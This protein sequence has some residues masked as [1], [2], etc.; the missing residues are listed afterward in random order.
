MRQLMEQNNKKTDQELLNLIESIAFFY[1][2]AVSHN[3]LADILDIPVEKVKEL[4]N[5]LADEY[6][7]RGINFINRHNELQIVAV[8]KDDQIL[9]K[10]EQNSKNQV[11][12]PAT[13]ETLSICL[14]LQKANE[15]TIDSIRGVRSARTIK[16]LLRRGYLEKVD[17]DK[18]KLS[19]E[20][21]KQLGVVS[22]DDIPHASTIKLKLIALATNNE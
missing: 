10:L 5:K 4:A 6:S 7:D 19:T 20:A 15:A 3:D 14:Y 2:E 12:T 1:N 9:D 21:Q 16:K 11:L 8:I 13:L 22:L 18:Y 17:G